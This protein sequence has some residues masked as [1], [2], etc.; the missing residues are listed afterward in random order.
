MSIKKISILLILIFKFQVFSQT[1]TWSK[2]YGTTGNEW[3]VSVILT[4]DDGYLAVGQIDN[5]HRPDIWLLKFNAFGDTLWTKTFGGSGN[6]RGFSCLQS[7]NGN[8]IIAGQIQSGWEGDYDAWIFETDVNGDTLWS[9]TYGGTHSDCATSIQQTNDNGYVIAGYTFSYGAG[10]ADAWILK[11]DL[12]GDTLWTKTFGGEGGD[13]CNS[14]KQTQDNGFILVGSTSSFGAGSTDLWLLKLNMNGDTLWTKT[15]GTDGI[16][17]GYSVIVSSDSTYVITGQTKSNQNPYEIWLLKVNSDGDL[18][19]DKIFINS[20]FD[21][22]SCIIQTSDGGYV[23]TGIWDNTY[24][25]LL[26]LKTNKNGEKQW[27]KTYGGPDNDQGISVQQTLDGGFIVAGRT[28]SYGNGFADVW[29]I[30]T[31]SLGINSI[32]EENK[33][34]ID[35]T[36]IKNYPNPFN[37]S[38][39]FEIEIPETGDLQLQIFDIYGKI[40]YEKEV[41]RVPAITLKINWDGLSSKGIPISSGIYFYRFIFTGINGINQIQSRKMIVIK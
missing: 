4:S 36:L 13:V 6:D 14:I 21:V 32:P 39:T 17:K 15:F 23:I 30:K 34:V 27:I 10:G 2:T 20:G 8:Y 16:D 7:N 40:V 3:A 26:L 35:H 24:Y 28:D 5:I 25:D 12:H 18:L 41:G 38:T 31:D 11:T 1:L 37:N 33:L 22:G 9:K 29:L 19:W